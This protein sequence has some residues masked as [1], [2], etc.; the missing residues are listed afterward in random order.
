VTDFD[1][2]SM[3]VTDPVFGAQL[4]HMPL[5]TH[6]ESACAGR[7]TPCCI[8]H[9]SEHHMRAWEMCWRADKGVMERTC[10][11]GIGHPDPDHLAYARSVQG[12]DADWQGVHGCDGCCRTTT[13]ES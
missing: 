4:G 1:L 3:Q 9:P 6:P 10:L 2:T 8:H 5:K 12:E 13:L 7:E 11:H